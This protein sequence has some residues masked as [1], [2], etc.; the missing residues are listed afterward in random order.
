ML[1]M[2][3]LPVTAEAIANR[4]QRMNREPPFYPCLCERE[5]TPVR[6]HTV[7]T[8]VTSVC[9]C[10]HNTCISRTSPGHRP[11][12]G[13]AQLRLLN[14]SDGAWE[15]QQNRFDNRTHDTLLNEAMIKTCIVHIMSR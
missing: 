2:I 3:P 10:A 7:G 1:L 15:C 12:K 13:G 9:A 11:P 14:Y 5:V 6:N 8:T 4:L